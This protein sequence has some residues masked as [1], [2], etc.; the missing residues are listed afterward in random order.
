[1]KQDNN[2]IY[3]TYNGASI[4]DPELPLD[5]SENSFIQHLSQKGIKINIDPL[6]KT[7]QHL[8]Q[9]SSNSSIKLQYCIWYSS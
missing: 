7:L 8:S 5:F 6:R 4:D 9:D 1:M 2:Q 3:F